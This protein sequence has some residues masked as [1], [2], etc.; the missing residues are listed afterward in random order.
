MEIIDNYEVPKLPFNQSQLRNSIISPRKSPS[1]WYTKLLKRDSDSTF[2]FSCQLKWR[3]DQAQEQIEEDHDRYSLVTDDCLDYSGSGGSSTETSDSEPEKQPNYSITRNQFKENYFLGVEIGCGATCT[4]HLVTKKKSGERFAAKIIPTK[5]VFTKHFKTISK[6]ITIIK[7]LN[8]PNIIKL[9][10]CFLTLDNVYIIMDF[11]DGDELF[12]EMLKRRIFSE[13]AARAIV[14]QILE[15]LIY[16]HKKNIA[17]RDIKP[18]NIKFSGPS[19]MKLLDFGFAR[20]LQVEGNNN[21]ANLPS[22]TLGYEAP[23]ILMNAKNQTT[24]VD[25]WAVGVIVYTMLCGYTPFTSDEMFH[26]EDQ[27]NNTPFWVMFNENTPRLRR[28]IMEAQFNFDSYHWKDVSSDAKDFISGLLTVD[29]S[30]R[31]KAEDAINHPWLKTP[32]DITSI[33]LSLRQL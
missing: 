8:H 2:S 12:E 5:K 31:L 11:V 22:G 14:K 29:P 19:S 7:T 13:N 1:K 10:E 32:L 27:I 6:E 17:H 25:M 28:S 24:A 15:P 33:T 3:L 30:Q 9:Y 4:V 26:E 16:L 23:E 20:Y 21:N 18:E